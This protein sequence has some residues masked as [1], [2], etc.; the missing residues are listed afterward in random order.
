MAT[1]VARATFAQEHSCPASKMKQIEARYRVNF[2][3]QILMGPT[4]PNTQ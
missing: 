2:K 1:R 4:D 3:N